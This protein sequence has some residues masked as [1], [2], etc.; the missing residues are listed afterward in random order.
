LVNRACP[1]KTQV[2]SKVAK[3]ITA[4]KILGKW[5]EP[6]ALRPSLASEFSWSGRQGRLRLA[7]YDCP[8]PVLPLRFPTRQSQIENVT[9]TPVGLYLPVAHIPNVSTTV[10]NNH[11]IP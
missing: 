11:F 7:G 10:S 2:E 6:A 5:M 4:R 9:F 8:E 1:P 3:L